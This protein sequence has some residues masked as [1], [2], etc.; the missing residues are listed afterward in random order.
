MKPRK[1]STEAGSI[2]LL[3]T[4]RHIV[5]YRA[6]IA[7]LLAGC[8]SER[9]SRPRSYRTACNVC[10]GMVVATATR[11]IEERLPWTSRVVVCSRACMVISPIRWALLLRSPTDE[12]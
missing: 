10:R 7:A 6:F 2:G 12:G 1:R 9:S 4:L 5:H 8:S 3:L 11:L